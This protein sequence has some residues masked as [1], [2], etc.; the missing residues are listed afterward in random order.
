MN[1]LELLL[2]LGGLS[3]Y[4]SRDCHAVQN[5]G[6]QPELLEQIPKT[7]RL[8]LRDEVEEQ[9]RC[10]VGELGQG[11]GTVAVLTITAEIVHPDRINT[12]E[13]SSHLTEHVGKTVGSE[14]LGESFANSFRNL[15]GC[16]EHLQQPTGGVESGQCHRQLLLTFGFRK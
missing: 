14:C 12:A 2:R 13:R 1:E 10:D 11:A 6:G 15:G 7:Q 16:V 5:L 3:P 8:R 4:W 9:F